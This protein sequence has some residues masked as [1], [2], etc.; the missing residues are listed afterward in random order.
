MS[1]TEQFP[2]FHGKHAKPTITR[3]QISPIE[4]DIESLLID[5]WLMEYT[6]GRYHLPR[7]TLQPLE[8]RFPTSLIS[9]CTLN[10]PPV[11]EHPDGEGN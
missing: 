1:W 10:L 5:F 4:G 9:H 2:P 8:C 3:P 6:I 11:T 7:K